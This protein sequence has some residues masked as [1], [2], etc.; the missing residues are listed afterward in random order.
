[1]DKLIILLF[2]ISFIRFLS[3]L[4]TNR[5]K[6]IYN[7]FSSSLV[8]FL[9]TCGYIYPVQQY[10]NYYETLLEDVPV[11]NWLLPSQIDS[12]VEIPVDPTFMSEFMRIIAQYNSFLVFF[13]IYYIIIK[14]GKKYNINYFIRYNVMN[15]LLITILSVPITYIYF[16]L[17]QVLTL[18]EFFKLFTEQLCFGLMMVH[19]FVL[20]YSM[21][22][23]V[24]N[25]YANLPIINDACEL[26]IG[27]KEPR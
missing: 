2:I 17:T 22:F 1:M 19:F 26:H 15:G 12:G 8:S 11:I 9:A 20:V 10:I 27:K 23:S 13:C 25:Q 18:S 14:K 4:V 21:Y 24:T 6:T 3:L 16:E 7:A 5:S